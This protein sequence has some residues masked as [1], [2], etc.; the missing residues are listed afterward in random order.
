MRGSQ[1]SCAEDSVREDERHVCLAP[2]LLGPLATRLAHLLRDR[3]VS[4]LTVRSTDKECKGIVQIGIID[5]DGD[6]ADEE[7]AVVSAITTCMKGPDSLDPGLDSV[8]I[9]FGKVG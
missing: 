6:V 4:T 1:L 2:V 5:L 8:R 9:P 3:V 7:S